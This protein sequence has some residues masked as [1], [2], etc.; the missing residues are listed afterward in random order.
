MNSDDRTRV[1]AILRTR[2]YVERS[3][4]ITLRAGKTI[5]IRHFARSTNQTTD[6]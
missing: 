4:T 2:G 6:R 3:R 5:V 1:A